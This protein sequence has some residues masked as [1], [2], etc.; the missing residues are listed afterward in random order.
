MDDQLVKE[1]V[2]PP[3][4][5]DTKKKASSPATGNPTNTGSGTSKK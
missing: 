4:E 1:G 2:L 5:E 3:R